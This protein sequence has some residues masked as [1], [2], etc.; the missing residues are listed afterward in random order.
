MEEKKRAER[1]RTITLLPQEIP[2][3]ESKLIKPDFFT[4]NFTKV[5]EEQ[6]LEAI[7]DKTINDDLLH[8][9]DFLP[10]SFADLII[11]D[12]PYNLTKNFNGNTFNARTEQEYDE[13]LATWFGKVCKKLKLCPLN[14]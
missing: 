7:I 11:I 3:L 2:E 13:Y 12:P 5:S 9:I 10:D 4:E 6:K 8:A 1:N 14:S